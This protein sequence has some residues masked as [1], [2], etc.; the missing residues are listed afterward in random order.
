ME[1]Q[2]IYIVKLFFFLTSHKDELCV[3][4][5]VT[6]WYKELLSYSMNISGYRIEKHFQRILFAFWIVRRERIW[7]F[8]KLE[9]VLKNDFGHFLKF[10]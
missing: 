8:L 9:L 1:C 2:K 7:K 3:T 6:D 4:L 5:A 10:L